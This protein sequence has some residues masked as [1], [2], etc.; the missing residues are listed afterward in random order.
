ML[1]KKRGC[2]I[3]IYAHDCRLTLMLIDRYQLTFDMSIHVNN[4]SLSC[5]LTNKQ[6]IC[7]SSLILCDR[8]IL[9]IIHKLP[10]CPQIVGSLN[11]IMAEF[12]KPE[13]LS[14]SGN[15]AE[16]WRLFEE[17]FD[18]F[19]EAAH[20]NKSN[21]EK[22]YI[23]LNIAGKEAIEKARSFEYKAAVVG[24]DGQVITPAESKENLAVLKQKFKDLCQPQRN[25]TMERYTFNTRSQAPN[26][27]IQSYIA[28]LKTLANSCEFGPLHDDLIRDRVVCGIA[29]NNVRKLLL[30]EHN[31]TLARAHEICKINEQT[32]A[33]LQ[34]LSR[35]AAT[36]SVH[37]LRPANRRINQTKF[38]GKSQKSQGARAYPSHANTGSASDRPQHVKCSNCDETHPRNRCKAYGKKCLHCGNLGH[39]KKCCRK[40]KRERSNQVHELDQQGNDTSQDDYF[41]VEDLYVGNIDNNNDDNI[42]LAPVEI[43]GVDT[44]IKVDTGARCNVVPMH[45]VHQVGGESQVNRNIHPQLKA[46]GGSRIK[47]IGAVEFPLKPVTGESHKVNFYVVNQNVQPILGCRDALRLGFISLGDNLVHE[48][49]A[50]PAAPEIEAYSELFGDDLGRLPVRYK[51]TLDESVPPVVRPPRRVPKP[52]EEAVKTELHRMT[53]LG[54]ITPISEPTDW[55]SSMVAQRKKNTDQ[56]RVCIDPKDLNRALKRPHHPMRTVEEVMMNLSDCKV[57]SILDATNSFWQIP[58]D[59]R[60]SKLTT[61]N[62]IL[63]RYRFLRMPYGLNSGSEVFQST[64][65]QLFSG[66]PCEIIVDDILVT[67]RDLEEHDKNLKAVLDRA[68]EVG[69][70][71]NPNK[72][73]FRQSQVSYVGHL[74]TDEGCKPDPEKV[75]AIAEMPV[76]TDTAAVHR[77]LGMLTYLGKFI[78]NLSEITAPLRELLHDNVHW[79]WDHPQQQAFDKLKSMVMSPPILTFYDVYKPVVITCDASQ[80]GLGCALLQNNQPVAFASRTLTET[81]KRYAQIEKEMLAIVFSC[82]KFH[83]YIYGKEILVE[84]D[85]QPLVTIMNKPLLNAPARLQSM[86]LTL[87]RY[88]LK[89]VYKKGKE[90]YLADTLSRAPR[91]QSVPD[92]FDYEVMTVSRISEAKTEELRQATASDNTLQKLIATINRGWPESERHVPPDIRSY[93]SFRDELAIEDGIVLKGAKAIIPESLHK[94]YAAI[95]HRGHI[96]VDA[97]KRR[98]R[99]IVY[100]PSM[101]CDITEH[102]NACATCNS[103]K[104]HQQKEPLNLHEIP[105]LPW[106]IVAT[107]LF[108][109]NNLHYIVIVDSYS[110]WF[111]MN[112]L[113]DLKAETIITKLKRSFAT[114]GVP[115]LLISDNGGQYASQQFEQFSKDWNFKHVTSSPEYAQSNGLAENAVKQ[116]KQIL[117]KTRRDGSDVYMNLLNVRNVPRDNTLGSP[118]QRLMSRVTRNAIYTHSSLLKPK[119]MKPRLVN[120]QL[121]K[122]RSQQKL[123]YDKQSIPLQPLTPNQ[124]VR[125]QTKK[126]YDPTGTVTKI[127]SQP[128]SY[129][130]NIGSKT[131]RRNR[132]HLIPVIETPPATAPISQPSAASVVQ[133]GVQAQQPEVQPTSEKAHTTRQANIG[134]APPLPAA[135]KTASPVKT[136]SGRI[137]KPNSKYRDFER[138]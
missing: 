25:I 93:F 17:D 14:F 66:Y 120:K 105:D 132:R 121:K 69:L 64:M 48:I 22:A 84:T 10:W 70:R 135:Q 58:L 87:Q 97:T 110:G 86:M 138:Y 16:N 4:A 82:R 115:Q 51:M 119:T 53:K 35:P 68:R 52:M 27:S 30:K 112:S 77:F 15:V 8:L 67:G 75:A 6:C 81:E 109:W 134:T 42:I 94:P 36:N 24:E 19:I 106:Q 129:E 130:V 90:L 41:E 104:Y 72:C 21:K 65:E 18:I 73:K 55:V 98:A 74:M 29:N 85:H 91:T 45:L 54:V 79:H 71:L 56:I 57:F 12:R 7:I 101:N 123:Y 133:P 20:G 131:I 28:D 11:V 60:S 32:E 1:S 96:G 40:L 95:M 127:L 31:L 23:L 122:K 50:S 128:R 100:W 116:A 99:E 118:A 63:G 26:E 9:L 80:F 33:H 34:T 137:S 89:L 108:E 117:E 92:R 43:N 49:S 76:P 47:T 62:T 126:G 114:H 46:F 13:P 113:K 61:F 124:T 39:F 111:E 78:D 125:I 37:E 38:K 136:R 3:S 107:D 59:E 103:L 102:V 88:N 5:H 44:E 2:K 83:Q